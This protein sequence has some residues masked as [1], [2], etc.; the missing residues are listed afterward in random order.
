[1]GMQKFVESVEMDYILS[2]P[3]VVV[4]DDDGMVDNDTRTKTVAEVVS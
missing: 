1:M 3:F 4:V 2:I